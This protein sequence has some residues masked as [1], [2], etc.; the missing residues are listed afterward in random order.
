MGHTNGE[1]PTSSLKTNAGSCCELL[2]KIKS[3]SGGTKSEESGERGGER[4]EGRG[5]Q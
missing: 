2:R 1:V 3:R 4:G 5:K